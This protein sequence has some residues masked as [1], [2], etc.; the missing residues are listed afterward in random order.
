MRKL[1]LILVIFWSFNAFASVQDTSKK[2]K[3]L[4]L[5]IGPLNPNIGLSYFEQKQRLIITSSLLYWQ[6]GFGYGEFFTFNRNTIYVD[7]FSG[8]KLIN[9]NFGLTIG[10]AASYSRTLYSRSPRI[11][12]DAQWQLGLRLDYK[13]FFVF[14]FGIGKTFY[15]DYYKN[16]YAS[17]T[18]ILF[19]IPILKK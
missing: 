7:I 5:S 13:N 16:I 10:S 11:N 12:Y 18:F 9:Q 14:Y 8:Y 2:V 17:H 3:L 19:N 6:E 15:T 1:S 4:S